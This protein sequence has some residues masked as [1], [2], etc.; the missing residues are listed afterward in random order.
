MGSDEAEIANVGVTVTPK[1]KTTVAGKVVTFK[2]SVK[3]NG[4]E[5]AD[6]VTL[7]DKLPVKLRRVSVAGCTGALVTGCRV[8]DIPFGATRTVTIKARALRSGKV[9]NKARVTSF[10][11][12][13]KPGNDS[14]S[15]AL[16]IR[17]SLTNLT[18]KPKTWSDE[19]TIRF[20]LS[21]PGQVTLAFARKG[22][23]GKFHKVGSRKG[24]GKRG[25]NVVSFSGSL[26][27]GK[28]LSPGSY[29]LTARVKDS[30]GRTSPAKR[31]K[32]KL[33]S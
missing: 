22:K 29:R 3:N 25:K 33:T 20:T 12:D 1:T 31:L 16:T 10:A 27:G 6:G 23:D 30:G 28:S 5:E 19:T 8:G 18:M 11:A 7:F 24:S 14:A 4:P 13:P 26:G 9:V 32:F 15:T 17:P 2:Y 21:D